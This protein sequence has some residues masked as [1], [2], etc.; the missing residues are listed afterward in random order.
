MVI[1]VSVVL[2][3]PQNACTLVHSFVLLSSSSSFSSFPPYLPPSLPSSITT[4]CTFILLDKGNPSSL[5]PSFSTSSMVG[6][7]NLFFNDQD[8]DLSIAEI[9]I[10]IAEPKARGKGMGKEGAGM[11]MCYAV[12]KLGVK[13]FYCK[14][15]EDNVAS[16]R[17]FEG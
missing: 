8:N 6:D 10:M 14:V 12:D 2:F 13:R 9:E 4:E 1:F 17:M 7:V 5:P 15:S 11:M 3:F 16:L